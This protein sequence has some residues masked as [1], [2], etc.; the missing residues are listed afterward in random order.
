MTYF[1]GAVAAVPTA[2]KDKYADHVAAAWPLFRSYGAIRMVE[3]WGADVPKGKVTDFQGAVDAREDE[4]IVFSWIEWPDKA[5]ADASW[6]K[7]QDDPAMKDMPEM[8]FD[9]SRMVFGGFAPVYEAGT[10]SGAGYYQGFL[11]AVP[12]K[13]KAPYV[14]MADEGWKMF[15]KGGA[16]GMVECWGED[17]PRGKK[18][19]LYRATRAEDGEVPVFS[20]AAWPDRAT[21]D[22]AA[23]AMEAEMGDMQDMPEMP[24]DGMRMMWAGFDPLFDSGK[25]T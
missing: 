25:A 20:W 12:E 14:E 11:L 3:T 4:T 24:F 15:Q 6:Q 17:V 23:K 9:G 13:N 21:C 10:H 8:P 16:L 1:T 18:T 22:A 19:D 7:M 2:N 5:T